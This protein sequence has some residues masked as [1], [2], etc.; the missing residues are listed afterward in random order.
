MLTKRLEKVQTQRTQQRRYDVWLTTQGEKDRAA[1]EM[2][3]A[4][5]DQAL[6]ASLDKREED[7]KAQL[8]AQLAA[9]Q[10]RK[11][12]QSAP[13]QQQGP[14]A[15]PARKEGLQGWTAFLLSQTNAL[16]DVYAQACEHAATQGVPPA[17]VRTVM[18]S[19]FIGLQRKGG[20]TNAR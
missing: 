7:I 18:L 13:A 3:A 4:P 8:T 16:I 19:A 5:L 14:V 2:A 9:I 1:V 15:V 17:V 6:E 10:Q 12:A 20:D 11:T